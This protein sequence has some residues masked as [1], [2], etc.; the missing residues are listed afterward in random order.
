M[1]QVTKTIL[2]YF[3]HTMLAF[4]LVFSGFPSQELIDF[5]KSK[6]EDRN[7]VDLMYLA[8]KDTSNLVDQD[9]KNLLRPEVSQVKA[10]GFQMQTGYYIG[11]NTDNRQIT[12]LGFQPDLVM[13]KDYTNAGNAGLL[14]KTSSMPGE[15]TVTI[16]ETDAAL[17]TNAIQSLDADGFTVG[18]NVDVNT[19]LMVY[20]WVAFG[21]SDCSS[22]GNFCVGSYVGNGSSQNITSVGFQPDFVSVKRT[23]T[24][25]G[26]LKTSAHSGT[27][28]SSWA[29]LADIAS[30]GISSLN[31]NGFSV[32]NNASANAGSNNY[33]YFAFKN[34]P[35]AFDV[36][37][38]VGTGVDGND[39]NSTDDPDLNFQSDFVMVRSTAATQ[40]YMNFR[41]SYGDISQATTDISGTTDII[42]K[43]YPTGGFQVG[44]NSIVNAVGATYY[45]LVFGGAEQKLAGTEKFQMMNGSYVGTGSPF[46]VTGLPFEPD[47]VIIKHQDQATDQY[48]VW[49]SK[50]M[51][52]GDS[53]AYFA[54]G[55]ANIA[56]AITALGS[57]GFSLGTNATVNTLDD[58]YYWTAF[59]NA[60]LP[61]KAGR[62]SDFLIGNYLGVIT[63]NTNIDRLP[64]QPEFLTVKRL[65]AS[66]G[67]WRTSAISGDSSTFFHASAPAGNRIQAFN[68]DG[69][70]IG[71]ADINTGNTLHSYFAFSGSDCSES[72]K[73]CVGSYLGNEIPRDID[74]G[75]QPDMVWI[76]RR[77]AGTGIGAYLRM[78][79]QTG[80]TISPFL[81]AASTA[82]GGIV[83]FISTGFSLGNGLGVNA[84]GITSDFVAWD[85]KRYTQSSYR[86]FE[87]IDS[88]DVGAALNSQDTPTTLTTTGDDFRLR[89]NLRSDYGNLFVSGKDLKLQYVDKGSG[90]CSSPSGGT[91]SSYTDVSAATLIAFN[92]NTTPADDSAL[93]ANGNDPTDSGRT[94]V[95]QSYVEANPFTNNQA[96][97][98]NQSQSGKWDFSLKDNGAP[99][100]TTYCFRVV[101]NASDTPLDT[102]SFYPEVIT[103]SLGGAQEI[104]MTISDNSI[105]F[106]SLSPSSARYATGDTL[107]SGTDSSDAHTVTASTNASGGYILTVNGTTLTCNA[108]S[109]ATI[110]SIGGTSTA[111]S[112]GT[113]QF[114]I[115]AVVNSGTGT[116]SVPYNQAS[117]FAF[118]AAA[119]PD[120][121]ATGGG[122]NTP[123][124]YGVRYLGNITSLTEAGVYNGILTYTVTASY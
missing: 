46:A 105:G 52:I 104:S 108:C 41:E 94:I 31:S 76:K 81:N 48:A 54:A 103:A 36:G 35:G 6:I 11:D 25:V 88:T 98:T 2:K 20:Y 16:A 87:N 117:E 99:A 45:Y 95:N 14:V 91:P 74:T 5:T 123:T 66:I 21:G 63:D 9:I 19:Q 82:V 29:N 71:N 109:G 3:I 107:G 75:F 42:Q 112:P 119:F 65:G 33:Y 118:D 58:T 18:T 44:T 97:I 12:G 39:I 90:T 50:M 57:N 49:K 51:G 72:G 34:T 43:L 24:S 111:S 93:T 101:G 116:V 80:D 38:Y 68:P 47:L 69:F 106:G 17:S 56:G 73:F 59:G 15:L 121:I 84:T 8:T 30:G 100:N 40:M 70:Q 4:L 27:V 110:D 1:F 102:Y 113:E 92:D 32:G 37:T 122:D 13:I 86:F 10:A 7:V 83:N 55:S 62:A 22:S 26:L 78:S 115:R 114:G 60:M 53:T 77:A 89:L 85:A 79:V 96:S 124:E 67:V 61:D 23:S 120:Q 64:I 28:S